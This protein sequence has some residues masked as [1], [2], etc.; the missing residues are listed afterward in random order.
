MVARLIWLALCL[1]AA[2]SF[3]FAQNS[4]AQSEQAYPTKPI[5]LIAPYGPGGPSDILARMLGERLAAILGQPVVVENK[6][7]AGTT[8]ATRMIADAPRDGYTLILSD[9]PHALNPAVFDKIPYD[10]VKD[11]TPIA[12]VARAP[13]FLFVNSSQPVKNAEDFVRLAKARPGQITVGSGGNGTVAHLIIALLEHAANISVTH[14]PYNG[15]ARSTMGAAAGEIDAVIAFLPAALPHV[16]SG[17]LRPVAISLSQRDPAYPDVPTFEESGIS[18]MVLQGWWG[19]LAPAGLP[20][21]IQ[22]KLNKAFI[23]AVSDATVQERYKT[24]LIEPATSSP[25]ELGA[26]IAADLQRWT[27]VARE[28][29]IKLQ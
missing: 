4:A 11:F 10:P 16:Q 23:E 12:L 25:E 13:T 9:T 5:H 21:P 8:I 29:G 26:L 22:L 24:L 6:P 3:S 20:R 15:S 2:A 19:I 7:G 27:R 17:R 14:V 28:A 1:V 18:N